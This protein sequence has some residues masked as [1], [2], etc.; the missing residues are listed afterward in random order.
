MSYIPFAFV[1]PNIA[2]GI[3]LTNWRWGYGMFCIIMPTCL[4][5]IV[6]VLVAA[7][8]RP[9][10]RGADDAKR[11]TLI[12]R[13]IGHALLVVDAVGLILVGFGFVLLLAPTTLYARAENGW[14]NPSMIVMEVVGGVIFILFCCWEW[15]FASYPLLTRRILNRNYCLS[16]VVAIIQYL[17][18]TMYN[19]YWSSWV[20]VVQEYSERQWTYISETNTVSLCVFTLLGGLTLRYVGRYKTIQILG[21]SVCVIGAGVNYYSSVY[22]KTSTAS[23][24]MTQILIQGGSG[25]GLLA[26]QTVS[27]GCVKHEDLAI[28]IAVWIF[29]EYMATGISGAAAGAIWSNNLQANLLKYAPNLNA[30]EIIFITGDITIARTSEP[31]AAIIHAYDDTYRKI[32]LVVLILFFLP[33]I[34]S[35]FNIDFRF[36]NRQDATQEDDE[37]DRSTSGGKGTRYH[38]TRG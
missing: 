37:G 5:P 12:S 23:L 11:E 10:R 26:A 8:R 35:F 20:W 28:S 15:K 33:V 32:S 14:K 9:L 24:V 13:R 36:D 38:V 21:Q 27:Q 6:L 4:T 19:T 1:A 29:I 16:V 25:F 7:E 30:T 2:S 22:G 17:C 34:S 31:R 18:G 3:G